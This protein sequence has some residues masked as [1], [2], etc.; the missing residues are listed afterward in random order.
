MSLP[1]QFR[2]PQ[3]ELKMAFN[4][5]VAN[6][7]RNLVNESLHGLARL[8]SKIRVDDNFRVVYRRDVPQNQVALVSG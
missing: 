5:H 4:K 6:E 8:N 7:P 2:D 1:L 3:N